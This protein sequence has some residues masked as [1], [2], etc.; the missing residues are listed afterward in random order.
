VEGPEKGELLLLGWGGTYGALKVTAI[1]LQNQGYKVAHAHLR[2][3]KPLPKNLGE[4]LHNYDKIVVPEINNGQLVK[5]I[6]DK[7]LLP[8]IPIN[9]IQG[10]PFTKTE[11]VA[12]VKE[13]L[14]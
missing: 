2:H 3:L 7:Y 9:K 14:G 12:K 4:I 6:R 1:E 13:L 5:V 8:A 10:V 11:L